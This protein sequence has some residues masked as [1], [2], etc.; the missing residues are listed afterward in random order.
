M[1]QLSSPASLAEGDLRRFHPIPTGTGY[2]IPVNWYSAGDNPLANLLFMPALG[3]PAR[4][5]FPLA[6]ELSSRGFNVALMEHRGYGDSNLRASRAVD[7][8]F[9]EAVDL[10]IP[11][12]MEWMQQQSPDL[13]LLSMGHS[14]GGHYSAI[15]AGLM[16]EQLDGVILVACGTPWTAVYSGAMFFQIKLLSFMIDIIPPLVGYYPGHRLG[17]GGREAKT[18]MKDWV[19]MARENRYV[20]HGLNKDLDVG[21]AHWKGKLLSLRL[22]DD[23]FASEAAMGAVTDKF[24]QADITKVVVDAQTL[25]DKA[26]HYRWIRTPHVIGETVLDW[27]QSA[28]TESAQ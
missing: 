12:V 6:A 13:P 19:M 28:F 22:A 17:F 24:K 9:R 11:V 27:F 26:D 21:I 15:M 1:T 8:G 25:G 3:V 18:L 23:A 14:L 5:C 7:F 4:Y 10:D 16:K 2:Q 20:A